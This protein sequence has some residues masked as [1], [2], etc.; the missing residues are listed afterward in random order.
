MNTRLIFAMYVLCFAVVL[1][2]APCAPAPEPTQ[3]SREDLRTL[4]GHVHGNQEKPLAD[5]VVYLKNTKTLVVKTYITEE[6]GTYRFP[7]LSTNVD[8]EV[9]AE[10]KG[11]HSDTKTLSSFDSRKEAIINLKINSNK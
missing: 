10:Y 5:A 1:P 9:H 6:N 8:Y 11:A 2:A 4:V 3:R 7:A